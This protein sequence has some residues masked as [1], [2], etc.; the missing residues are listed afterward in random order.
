M[1]V[2]TYVAKPSRKLS[3]VSFSKSQ[4]VLGPTLLVERL[5]FI[6]PKPRCW[7]SW[8]NVPLTAAASRFQSRRE[9]DPRMRRGL[10]LSA[11]E[12][13]M[14][15]NRYEAPKV[16]SLAKACTKPVQ[17]L[18]WYGPVPWET[19]D[20]NSSHTL[21]SPFIPC[22]LIPRYHHPGPCDWSLPHHD[23]AWFTGS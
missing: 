20:G 3:H 5:S 6:T 7:N 17:S 13:L 2:C 8:P 11:G 10:M 15:T 9:Q 4:N 21:L 18:Y 16:Q 14:T 22:S 23:D 12:F 19:G 1:A